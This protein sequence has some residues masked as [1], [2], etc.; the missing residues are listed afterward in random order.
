[1]P[2]KNTSL[3]F[4][5]AIKSNVVIDLSHWNVN[6]N[7]GLVKNNGI[8]AVIH[9]A[10]QGIKYVDPRYSTRRTA[11]EKYGLLWGAYHFG[12]NSNG[13]LQANHFLNTVGNTSKTLFVLDVEYNKN[14][15]MTQNQVKDFIK[16][17]Q[18]KT[19]NTLMIYGSYNT[20]INYS[21]P[22]L[23]KIPLWIAFYNWPPKVPSGWDKWFL[24]QYTDGKK[25]LLPHRVNGIG[26]CDRDIFNGSVDELK[27]FWSNYGSSLA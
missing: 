26:S 27:L 23:I 9:K 12:T 2:Y 18:Y 16:T 13:V 10:T 1:M 4:N 17:V 15:T 6:V 21:S 24:W 22:F 25:G 20:L 11:A 7:F 5:D 19:K 8:I 14:N 3:E